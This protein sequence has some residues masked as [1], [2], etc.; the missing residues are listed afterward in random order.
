[1]NRKIN[2]LI[3]MY[4][5]KLFA[6]NEKVLESLQRTV[7]IYSDDIGMEFGIKMCRNDNVKN[8]KWQKE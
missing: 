4:D 6:R 5:I 1:M 8:S 7:R 3:Y 2:H